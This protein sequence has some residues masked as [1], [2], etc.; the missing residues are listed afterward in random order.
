MMTGK[1]VKVLDIN[2]EFYGTP[3][4]KLME[5]AGKH[6]AEYIKETNNKPKVVVICGPGNNGGDGFV[7]ARYLSKNFSV[8]LFLIGKEESI[9]TSIA[10]MNFTKLKSLP[11]TLYDSRHLDKLKACMDD[12]T[13]IID[14]MLGVGIRGELRPPYDEIVPQINDL[15]GKQIVS[16]DIPTGLG[17]NTAVHP[18]TTITFHDKKPNMNEKTCGTIK[19]VD[20]QIP[21]KAQ[22]HVGPGE[23]S[24]YYP[25]SKK[26]SHKGQNGRVLV[27]G[28]GPF[29]GAP[30]LAGMAALRTGADLAFIASP[31][32]AADTI[33][34][35][36]PNLI[37]YPLKS[38][39]YLT[40]EDIPIITSKFNQIDSIIIGP[41]LG[42]NEK[43]KKAV[44][45]II[46]KAVS[47]TKKIVIDADAIQPLFNHYDFL[48]K[49][50]SVITPHSQEFFK[51]TGEKLS[52]ELDERKK[53]V[54][55]WADKI[56]ATIFLKGSIDILSDGNTTRLNS[57]HNPSMTVGGTGDVLTGIIAS[58]LAKHISP[59]KSARIAAFLNGDAGNQAFEKFS[60]GLLA[61]DIIENIPLVL[62][63]Y[64]K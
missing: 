17:T 16:V 41:G 11:I 59:M 23:L 38:K 15:K 56:G 51:L 58:L 5:N 43:T 24:V 57:V 6:V 3:P 55:T 2:S 53:Q 64:V 13:V 7:A 47:A 45:S 18:H 21:H 33:A 27:I 32:K 8:T 50:Q 48:K 14:A 62:K 26:E 61:T 34:S 1:E 19:I 39:R 20:I 12:A 46:Q 9:H 42:S 22:T 29:T 49:T 4:E 40:A 37:V 28:G 30:A 25:R 54:S 60:Y 35:F 63:T 52:N 36:N 31:Q 44:R 10:R